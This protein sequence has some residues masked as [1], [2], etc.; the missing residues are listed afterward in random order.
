VRVALVYPEVYDLARF[1]ERRKEF[2]PFGPLYLA[3]VAEAAGHDVEI[4]K[5]APGMETLD[6]RR[7]DAVGYSVSASATFDVIR[8]ARI[9]SRHA[10]GALV[11]AG[12]VHANFY[13]EQTLRDLK[14]D[15]VGVGDGEETFV[16]LLE[17]ASTRRFDRVAGVCFE[18]G[19][20]IVTTP[21]RAVVSDIDHLPL[22]ARHLLPAEDLI[23]TDRLSSTDIEMAHVMFSR[24]CP[25]RCRFCAVAGT[26]MQYRSGASAR[27]ELEHLIDAY[28]I[29]GFAVVDDNFIIHRRKVLDIC[30]SIED[31]DL[32]WSALSRVNTV[33]PELLASL[34]RA[35]C[36]ELKF[37]MESGSP[38]ILDGMRKNIS[39]DQIRKAVL[40]AR[41]ADINVKLFLIHGFPG[42]NLATTRETIALL[43][44][45]APAVE[46]ASL[47]RFVPLPGSDVYEHPERYRLRTT[48]IGDSRQG[49]WSEF[50]IHHNTHHWWGDDRDFAEVEAG[51]RELAEVVG[52]LWPDRHEPKPALAAA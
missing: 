17:E 32:R 30:E 4:F 2:P 40:D 48:R 52:T 31:L 50:H 37:G 26:P 43:Q 41:A 9:T 21:E 11:M 12:G 29:G 14:V 16:E 28:G 45:L 51:Y 20:E 38:K 1:K 19:G 36:I 47:F 44:E 6:L 42:E 46:R 27:R 23:M 25:Y 39:P 15:V 22:P 33:R 34:R 35:G 3:A 7:F 5:V 49:G 24:G 18:R 10:D 8:R 13:P